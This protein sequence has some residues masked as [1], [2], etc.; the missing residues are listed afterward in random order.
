MG[1]RNVLLLLLLGLTQ[2]KLD[3]LCQD[4]NITSTEQNRF[5]VSSQVVRWTT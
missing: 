4:T 1:M 3:I 5:L 2:G